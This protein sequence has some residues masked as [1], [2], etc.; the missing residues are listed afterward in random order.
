MSLKRKIIT[1][2]I[3]IEGGYVS[4]PSDSGGKTM[5]GVTEKVAR[6]FGYK[7]LMKNLPITTAFDVYEVMYWDSMMLDDVQDIAGDQIAEEIADT[8]VNMGVGRASKFLQRSLNTLNNKGTLYPDIAVDGSIGG[9]T[10]FSLKCFVNTR[11]DKGID[12]LFRMLNALQG[13]SYVGLA[14]RREKDEKFIYGWFK[15]RVL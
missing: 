1:A 15:N 7:G 13:A 10:L 8:G 3:E 12:V 4:D 5:Y 2:I 14:E 11:G 6:E 9:K